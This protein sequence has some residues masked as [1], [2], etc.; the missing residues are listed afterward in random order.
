MSSISCNTNKNVV[1]PI[2]S[3][4]TRRANSNK[5]FALLISL[6]HGVSGRSCEFKRS[7]IV[8]STGGSRC[9]PERRLGQDE[10]GNRIS[11]ADFLIMFN[12]NCESVLLSFRDMTT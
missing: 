5:S 2:K 8:F 11:D 4:S 3:R 1:D 10:C 6:R 12:S 9:V 7:M